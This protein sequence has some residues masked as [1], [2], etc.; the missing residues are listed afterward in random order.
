MFV[1]YNLIWI[2]IIFD[3]YSLVLKIK[4][5][6]SIFVNIMLRLKKINF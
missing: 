2:V 5:I 4:F 1:K 6:I 3:G